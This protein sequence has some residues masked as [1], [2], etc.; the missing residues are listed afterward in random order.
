M[1]LTRPKHR[2]RDR[3]ATE[4][5]LIGAAAVAFAQKGYENAT[6]RSIAQTANCSEGLIQRYFGGKEGLLLAVLKKKNKDTDQTR[7]LERPLCATLADEA[8]ETFFEATKADA[9]HSSQQFR[10]VLSRVM[11]DS[12]FRADFNRIVART[13]VRAG[14]EAR[15]ARYDSAGMIRPNLDIRSAAELLLSLIFQLGFMHREIYQTGAA[16]LERIIDGFSI[17]YGDAVSTPFVAK[18]KAK[19]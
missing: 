15:L 17:L 8:R 16:E 10:I 5:A 14:I 9:Q 4:D 18:S 7:F 13:Q 19:R 11:L 1:A 12:S 3:E 6:T 2:P